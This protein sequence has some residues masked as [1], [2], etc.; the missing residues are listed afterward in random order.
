MSVLHTEID[1]SGVATS[2]D[3]GWIK[4]QIAIAF[5]KWYEIHENDKVLG[6]KKLIIFSFT[7]RVKHL[8]PVFVLLFGNQP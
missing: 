4:D 3:L 7:V 6:F 8:R 2:T 5:W 1:I